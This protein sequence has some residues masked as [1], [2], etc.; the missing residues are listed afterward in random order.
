MHMCMQMCICACKC[1]YR[2]MQT[3]MHNHIHQKVDNRSLWVEDYSVFI[4]LYAYIFGIENL[5]NTNST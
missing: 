1:P 5:E 4:R 2:Y 3:H